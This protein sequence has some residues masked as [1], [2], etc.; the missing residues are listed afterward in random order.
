MIKLEKK[1]N[2]ILNRYNYLLI[3]SM[4]DWRLPVQLPSWKNR[5]QRRIPLYL[6]KELWKK[7]ISSG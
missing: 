2:Q 5:D 1:G 6:W 7:L 4:P 3:S